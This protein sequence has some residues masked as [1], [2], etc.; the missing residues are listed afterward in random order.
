MELMQ[1]LN[2]YN[3][4]EEYVKAGVP[5]ELSNLE[6]KERIS[7]FENEIE[8]GFVID[9][10]LGTMNCALGDFQPLGIN[11]QSLQQ[12]LEQFAIEYE[13]YDVMTEESDL[14]EKALI[15]YD[16]FVIGEH[17]FAKN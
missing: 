3:N 6:L 15:L 16:V 10:T 17:V 1:T 8:S 13:L 14:I 5:F 11:E 7:D 4:L 2:K 12:T 9:I